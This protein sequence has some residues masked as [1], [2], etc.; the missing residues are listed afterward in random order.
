ME[1]KNQNYIKEWYKNDCTVYAASTILEFQYPIIMTYGVIEKLASMSFI[2]KIL[3]LAWAHFQPMYNY[4]AGKISKETGL[5]IKVKTV[6]ITNPE[7]ENLVNMWFYFW[8]WLLLGN[9]AYTQAVWRGVLTKKDID[10]IKTKWRSFSHANVFWK[11]TDWTSILE[12]LRWK[13]VKCTLEV[14]RYWVEQW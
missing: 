11:G 10:V 12:V 13:E 7:Y 3:W 4:I 9:S 1:V 5:N 14:L 2:D 6:Q 8:T